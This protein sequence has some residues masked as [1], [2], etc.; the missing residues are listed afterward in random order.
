MGTVFYPAYNDGAPDKD[1]ERLLARLS[2]TPG[3][4]FSQ[5]TVKDVR[6]TFFDK[7]WL[8]K[9]DER[10]KINDVFIPAISGSM[11]LRVY[12]PQGKGLF[13][14]LLFFH[15]G[16]FVV[17]RV[18][19]FDSFCASI[20]VGANC[21]VVSADYRLA[22]E[23]K[24]PA[25]IEDLETVLK[26]LPVN[27]KSIGGDRNKIAVAGDSAGGNLAALASII[28]RDKGYAGIVHQVLICPWLDISLTERESYKFFGDGIWLSKSTMVWFRDH[29]INTNEDAKSYPASP[30]F[31]ENFS[32][33][34]PALIIAAELDVLA[35][36][37]RLFRDKLVSAGVPVQYSLY[38][39]TLHDF[40]T[41]PLLF[42][43]ANDAIEE[44]C[45]SLIKHFTL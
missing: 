33:L 39:G 28:D 4:P 7:E 18:E 44:V 8:A 43:R 22:P 26:W 14:I 34:P 24:F 35:D 11:R 13:P 25:Q 27:A 20:A 15:G 3:T 32:G 45:N 2:K 9:P 1:T 21:L 12:T 19:E 31:L 42:S 6:D 10:I 23:N 17:G 38:K 16:G 41:L 40:I 37:G 5:M 29:Y 30:I 36:E